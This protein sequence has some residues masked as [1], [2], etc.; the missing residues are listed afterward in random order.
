L[1]DPLPIWTGTTVVRTAPIET[2]APKRISL[3]T[4]D[5]ILQ[6]LKLRLNLEPPAAEL[7]ARHHDS[8]DRRALLNTH[9]AFIRARNGESKARDEDYNFHYAVIRASKNPFL[10]TVYEHLGNTIIPRSKLGDTEIETDAI[11]N[12]LTRVE[13]DHVY[14]LEA[15]LDRDPTTAQDMMF[16]H[17]ARARRMYAKYQKT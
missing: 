17:I 10:V 6:A 11:N 7:A 2:I 9:T 15:I 16:Q 4:V 12:Y 13:Q 3:A 14:I 5:D 1:H 8:E